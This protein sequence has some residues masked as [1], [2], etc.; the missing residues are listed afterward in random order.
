VKL[1]FPEVL[2]TGAGTTIMVLYGVLVAEWDST[3]Y[4]FGWWKGFRSF[5]IRDMKHHKTLIVLPNTDRGPGR[6]S[7]WHIIQSRYFAFG[8][9]SAHKPNPS[10]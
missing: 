10:V 6:A 4:H 7:F 9:C 3:A 8:Q 5:N 1:L 2:T